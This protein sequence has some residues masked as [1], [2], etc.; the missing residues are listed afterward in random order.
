MIFDSHSHY[1]D[2]KFDEDR[3]MLL[4]SMESR[5]ISTIVNVGSSLESSKKSIELAK[6]FPN[7]Y[8]A[9]GVHPNEAAE[10]T[11]DNL[12]KLKDMAGKAKVVAIG[13]IGLDYYWK[14]PP[15]QVQKKWFEEQIELA[16]Q[17]SLPM[18]IH[19]RDAAKDTIDILKEHKSE[20]IGGV[21]HCYSYSVEMA[22]EYLDMGFYFGI[23]GVVT[24]K[25]SKTI[26]EVVEY[27]PL[28]KIL[29]ETDCP[30]LA[31]EPNRGKRN[32]SLNIP[33]I[34]SEIAKIKKVTASEVMDITEENAANLY[35]T[36]R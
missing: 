17:V 22:K 16:R 23:G 34:I 36:N 35:G 1:D 26:K 15:E 7:V 9:V 18:I 5:G 2:E 3:D 30:Y 28:D 20:E 12:S 19:S 24:F 8:A 13:E 10:L 33:Y 29:V 14:E 4:D 31:P 21:I 32:S 6:R 27:L 25:N 11:L